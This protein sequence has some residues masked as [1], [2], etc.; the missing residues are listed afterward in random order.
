VGETVLFRAR[1]VYN[2]RRMLVVNR[3]TGKIIRI[4]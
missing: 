2:R 1:P 3:K 4:E